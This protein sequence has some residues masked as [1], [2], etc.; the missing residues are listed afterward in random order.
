M[1]DWQFLTFVLKTH[2]HTHT[3]THPDTHTHTHSSYIPL[4]SQW[5]KKKMSREKLESNASILLSIGYE[6]TLG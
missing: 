5:V 1:C 3:H 6:S 2:T 4:Q